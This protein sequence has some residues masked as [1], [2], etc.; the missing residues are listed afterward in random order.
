[1]NHLALVLTSSDSGTISR[2]SES[3]DSEVWRPI[4]YGHQGHLWKD[5]VEN[6][7]KAFPC[8][9]I[10]VLCKGE[11]DASVGFFREISMPY[12]EVW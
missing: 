12:L 9:C 6:D 5:I 3:S 4:T 1:M 11:T 7:P 10:I 2:Y 8:P